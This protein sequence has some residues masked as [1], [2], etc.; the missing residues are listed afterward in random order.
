MPRAL[1]ALITGLVAVLFAIAAALAVQIGTSLDGHAALSTQCAMSTDVPK[2]GGPYVESATVTAHAT[3][4]PL[5]VVCSYDAPGDQLGPQSVIHQS[6]L[7]TAV[8]V[9]AA[10]GSLA[11][12]AMTGGL[13]A[14]ALRKVT[15]ANT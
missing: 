12:V 15:N 4:F 7:W 6:W 13:A 1:R 9:L 2:V 5:G 3:Y 8:A 14:S 10:L 11:L